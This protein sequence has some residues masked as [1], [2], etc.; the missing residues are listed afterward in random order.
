MEPSFYHNQPELQSQIYNPSSLVQQSGVGGVQQSY[1][2]EGGGYQQPSVW[3]YDCYSAP[4]YSEWNQPWG[5]SYDD[6]YGGH[7]Q[8]QPPPP[9]PYYQEEPPY[10]C[11]HQETA[12]QEHTS[13]SLVEMLEGFIQRTDQRLK[14][15]FHQEI[16]PTQEWPQELQQTPLQQDH[17]T[18]TMRELFIEQGYEWPLKRD[19]NG[20]FA[21]RPCQAVQ[22]EQ[23]QIQSLE[24]GMAETSEEEDMYI[25]S[26]GEVGEAMADM[27]SLEVEQLEKQ[28][29]VANN[30]ATPLPLLVEESTPQPDHT[31][32]MGVCDPFELYMEDKSAKN[33]MLVAI[34]EQLGLE[35]LIGYQDGVGATKKPTKPL[36]GQLHESVTPHGWLNLDRVGVG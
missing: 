7:Y 31:I 33:G 24:N 34:R 1:W 16:M 30:T 13:K 36:I 25:P 27:I 9:S 6:P 26:V 35:E 21:R 2:N 29:D 32:Y 4:Q 15:Q 23:N 12:P 14:Q 11:W 18:K 22:Q 17:S 28:T 8:V 10:E 19:E 20:E 3:G 5:G